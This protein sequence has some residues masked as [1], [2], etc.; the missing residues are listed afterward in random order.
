VTSTE[1]PGVTGVLAAVIGSDESVTEVTEPLA[2]SPLT[3]VSWKVM[4]FVGAVAA[5]HVGHAE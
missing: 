2:V 4:V 5:A 3:V 1:A